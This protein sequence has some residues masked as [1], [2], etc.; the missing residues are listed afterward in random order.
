MASHA[1]TWYESMYQITDAILPFISVLNIFTIVGTIVLGCKEGAPPRAV[2][3]LRKISKVLAYIS[4]S[5][6]LFVQ[7]GIDV[8]L[9]C[10][11][12]TTATIFVNHL[13]VTTG[14]LVV[15]VVVLILEYIIEKQTEEVNETTELL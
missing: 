7:N 10:L 12:Q 2:L 4:A 6:A 9:L 1:Q 5:W 15:L 8:Y 13:F 3:W 14:A 11:S